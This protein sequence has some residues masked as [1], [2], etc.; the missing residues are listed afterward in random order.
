MAVFL[1]AEWRNLAVVTYRVDPAIL[2]PYLPPGLRLDQWKGEALMSLVGFQ[3]LGTRILGLPVP[4][5]GSFPEVNLRFYVCRNTAEGERRGVVFIK[6]IVP[7]SPV[8]A[9]ARGVY[10]EN[11]HPMRMTYGVAAGM[12]D[13]RWQWEGREN[14][15]AVY[16]KSLATL[17][18]DESLDTFIVEHHWGY[19]RSRDGTCIEYQVER[20]P[21]RTYPVE[22]FEVDV[23]VERMYGTP[24]AAALS[25]PPVSV[26]LAE[27]SRVA[28]S[29]GRRL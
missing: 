20:K 11:Y 15:I 18:D 3:F 27:G 9:V 12:A 7:Y 25:Q 22:R 29:F 26:L 1:T 21:W 23:D 5:W 19:S 16:A 28:V 24:F 13:Y 10:N 17:P 4:F 2:Q 8:A 14:R 6:E